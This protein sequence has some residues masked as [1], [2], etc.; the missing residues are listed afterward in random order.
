MVA[1]PRNFSTVRTR[2]HDV[3][4]LVLVLEITVDSLTLAL[5]MG[6]RPEG[7]GK[8]AICTGARRLLFDKPR[9]RL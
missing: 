2:D 9:R 8:T 7:F 4:V 3:P 1:H 5:T 6:P